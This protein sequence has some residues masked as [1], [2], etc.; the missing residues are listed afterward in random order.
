MHQRPVMTQQDLIKIFVAEY[1]LREDPGRSQRG[2]RPTST[3]PLGMIAGITGRTGANLV[4]AFFFASLFA[5][6][7]I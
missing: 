5:G 1:L 7:V 6:P 3:K 4:F 2:K